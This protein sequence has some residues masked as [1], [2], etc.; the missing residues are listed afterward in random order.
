MSTQTRTDL[1]A[2]YLRQLEDE[3]L[4][5]EHRRGKCPH[6]VFADGGHRV[7]RVPFYSLVDGGLPGDVLKTVCLECGKEWVKPG[8]GFVVRDQ[9]SRLGG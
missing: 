3:A 8:Q 5:K 2:N 7:G 4:F 9:P 6:S 1:D